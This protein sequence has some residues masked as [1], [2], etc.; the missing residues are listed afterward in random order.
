MLI[1][2]HLLQQVRLAVNFMKKIYSI[3]LTLL[4]TLMSC[5]NN[6]KI[7]YR[8]NED[9]TYAVLSISA[10]YE[11]DVVIPEKYKGVSVTEFGGNFIVVSD[12]DD[13]IRSI[14]IPGSIKYVKGGLLMG[15]KTLKKVKL[16][17]GVENIG[18]YSFSGCSNLTKINLP[19]SLKTIGEYSLASTDIT[20]IKIP[21]KLTEIGTGAF[22]ACDKIKNIEIHSEN[23]SFYLDDGLLYDVTSNSLYSIPASKTGIIKINDNCKEFRVNNLFINAKSLEFSKETRVIPEH[24]CNSYSLESIVLYNSLS[25]IE[26]HAFGE[27]TTI[28]YIYFYGTEAEWNSIIIGKW[29]SV[30]ENAKV[31]YMNN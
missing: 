6:A 20:E 11:S 3:F 17:D 1:Q 14:S 22:S 7:L 27:T 18:E 12:T 26:R 4:C 10:K 5:S 9:G 16:G 31:V 23:E 29:N 8:L 28:K 25:V 30:I 21:K 2:L 13:K 24:F 15:N 19:N